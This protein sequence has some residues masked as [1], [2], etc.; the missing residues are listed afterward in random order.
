MIN[1]TVGESTI[2]YFYKIESPSGKVYIG[3]TIDFNRRMKQY[4]TN[5][6]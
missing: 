6:Q 5:K 4:K 2:C 1:V 3:S